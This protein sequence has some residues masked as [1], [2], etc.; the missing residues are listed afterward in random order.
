MHKI[1]VEEVH[2]DLMLNI[3]DQM[4]K[5]V[6]VKEVDESKLE[7]EEIKAKLAKLDQK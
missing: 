2:K 7:A 1:I 3:L 6:V 4:R 5:Q